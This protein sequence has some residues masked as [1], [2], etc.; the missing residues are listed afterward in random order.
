MHDLEDLVNH[1]ENT[2]R[3]GRA[4]AFRVVQEVLAFFS[5]TAEGFVVRRHQEL[6]AEQLRNAAIYQ[7]ITAE[8]AARRF[9]GP[10]LS[11]RQIRRII[12]G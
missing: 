8:L 3:L 4:E 2:T 1:L 12:Y 5:E 9:A 10:R 6:Q 11:T 7:R